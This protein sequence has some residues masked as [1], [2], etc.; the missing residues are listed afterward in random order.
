MQG[1]IQRGGN[2]LQDAAIA[3]QH[4]LFEICDLWPNT[5]TAVTTVYQIQTFFVPGSVCSLLLTVIKVARKGSVFRYGVI[6]ST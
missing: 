1:K 5:S 2:G 3:R 4:V 6:A